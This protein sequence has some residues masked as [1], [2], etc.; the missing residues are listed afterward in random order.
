MY[1]LPS[2]IPLAL[3]FLGGISASNSDS[4][5]VTKLSV[6]TWESTPGTD[7]ENNNSFLTFL[8]THESA[9]VYCMYIGQHVTILRSLIDDTSLFPIQRPLQSD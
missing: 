5:Q 4:S 3:C 1:S 6:A 9:Y 2:L 7:L 8:K